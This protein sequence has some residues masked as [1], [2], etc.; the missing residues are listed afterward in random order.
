MGRIRSA[1]VWMVREAF[2][3]VPILGPLLQ[4]KARDHAAA[5]REFFGILFWSTATFWMTAV[6]LLAVS[7]N[8]DRGFLD[9]IYQT[10]SAGQLFVFSVSFVGPIVAAV[11]RDPPRARMFP[12]RVGHFSAFLALV[13]TAAG[14]YAM[15]LIAGG[16]EASTLLNRDFLF[17]ASLAIASVVVILRYLTMVYRQSTL[18]FDAETQLRTPTDAFA[19]EFSGRH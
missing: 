18:E 8:R 10:V 1:L 13:A 14:F 6:F 15:E 7:A 5:C 16:A 2:P 9:V 19:N 12:G 4:C 17:T 3:R 11:G